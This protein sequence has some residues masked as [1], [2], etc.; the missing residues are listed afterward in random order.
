[1]KQLNYILL[2]F[3]LIFAGC[4]SDDKL[5][6]TELPL[7][8]SEISFEATG[9][10][11]EIELGLGS[12][13]QVTS[14]KDWCTVAKFG[15]FLIVTAPLN[16]TIAVR[17]ATVT[18]TEAG[19]NGSVNITQTGSKF[20][21]FPEKVYLSASGKAQAVAVSSNIRWK[22]ESSQSWCHLLVQGDTLLVSADPYKNEKIAR[23][24]E[25]NIEVEGETVRTLFVTQIHYKDFNLEKWSETNVGATLPATAENLSGRQFKQTWGNFYQWG[26][27]VGFTYGEPIPLRASDPSITAEE[28]QQIPE[29]IT[30][31]DDWLI[32]GSFTTKIYSE[33]NPYG[34]VDRA[35][36]DPCEL[37]YRLPLAYECA[38][39]LTQANSLD[40]TNVTRTAGKEVLDA[41]GTEYT[42]VFIGN[43][44]QKA[45]MIKMFGTDEA[46]V[47]RY[48]FRG[49]AGY[50]GWMKITEIKGNARTD[51]QTPDQAEELF[52]RAGK[53]AERCFPLFGLLW[54]ENADLASPTTGTY[55]LST[56]SH[57]YTGTA[58]GFMMSGTN[59]G[60]GISYRKALGCPIRG[61]KK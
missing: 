19:N 31:I 4:D 39:I 46:Y 33:S 50:N 55:W 15:K 32:D 24:A 29:F 27:N 20:D 61:I 53:S 14:D 49:T 59:L 16:P 7:E 57:L 38:R 11:Q 25:I 42:Y 28:G 22:A 18:I 13:W 8:I 30:N 23:Q 35:G 40:F 2:I 9:G 52:T 10:T 56:P 36:Y 34:W 51:F 44:S 45:Y 60:F 21:T 5:I 48:E 3:T 37:G 41:I 26:R 43:G 54:G 1:M 58:N 12:D 6:P 47:M 17:T